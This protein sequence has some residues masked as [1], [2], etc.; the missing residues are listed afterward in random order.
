MN[1]FIKF[2]KSKLLLL[3]LLALI[4]G[5][6][7]AWAQK[8]LPYEYGFENNDLA[9][10]GW[11]TQNSSGKNNS[12]FIICSDAKKTGSYGFRF[13]SYTDSGENTQYLISPELSNTT[14]IIVSFY[15]AV[16]NSWGA[17]TF[18]VGYS[19]T[20]TDIA[21]FNWGDEIS[22]SSTSWTAYNNTFPAGTKYVA[23]YYYSNYKYRLY[24]DDFSFTKPATC[25]APTDPAIS[26][27]TSTSATLS[28]TSD[29]L[30]WN[31]QYKK[32]TDS[33]WTDVEGTVSEKS[34]IFSNLTPATSYDVRVRTY[35]D[36]SDQSTWTDAVS[37]TTD[38]AAI[39]EFPFSENFNS[40]TSGIPMCWNNAEGTV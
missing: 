32:S 36:A 18:K 12:E 11:T 6:S 40:I 20:D 22:T 35:C 2:R 13:S 26:E 38:C 4:V 34:Y 14:D 28:W 25:I 29:A 39:T 37:F 27:I 15:Y 8:A 3:T 1:D 9:T 5:G 7:P 17:E 21:N 30:T 16:S 10:E 24:V 23:I 31:I 19:T 33:D